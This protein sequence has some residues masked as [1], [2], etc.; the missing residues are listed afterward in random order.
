MKSYLRV[1]LTL[2]RNSF[3]RDMTFRANFIIDL[4]T[5]M[6]WMLMNLGFYILIFRYAGEIGVGTGWE[7]YPFFIFVA[8]S[9]LVNSV[10]EMFFMMNMDELSE[11]I[12]TGALDFALVKPIDTQFLVSLTK[13][14]WSAMGNFFLGLFL[15]GY[16]LLKLGYAPRFWEISLYP[17][18]IVC[19]V[20]IYYSLMVAMA[21]ASVWL[22]RN[23]TLLDFWFSVTMF[24]RYPMEI[25]QGRLG[26]P[27]R[28]GLT[29]FIPILVAVNV[30]ARL[31]VRSL[32]PQSFTDWLLPIFTIF[33]TL[34][35]LGVARWIFNRALTSYRSASS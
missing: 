23:L 5:W 12:R 18:Y 15:L 22:G 20:T 1:F 29:F 13:T 10:V 26:A 7:K 34:A 27:L 19:G 24:S 6:A 30:P 35:S 31:L 4:V 25:Y 21:A 16:S 9:L 17:V 14:D 28:R 11:L 2:A 32:S 33:A 3:V 8:T